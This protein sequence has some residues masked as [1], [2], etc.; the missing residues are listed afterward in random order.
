MLC[1]RIPLRCHDDITDPVEHFLS[2][3]ITPPKSE[4]VDISAK[5]LRVRGERGALSG[6]LLTLC[7]NMT[8][9]TSSNNSQIIH[10]IGHRIFVTN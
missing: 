2:T 4:N 5:F 8:S 7:L 6:I 1:K 3:F 9:I 10:F